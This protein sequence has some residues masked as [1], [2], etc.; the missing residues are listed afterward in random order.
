[1]KI[2]FWGTRGSI[3]VPGDQTLIYGGNTPCVEIR[4]KDEQIIILDAGSGIRKLG[5]D[6]TNR[7]F[8]KPINI[9]FSHY[10]WDH[11]QGLAFFEP[12]Y[13]KNFDINIFGV[14]IN[15]HSVK[16]ML[17]TQMSSNYFPVSLEDLKADISFHNI[18]IGESFIASGVKIETVKTKHTTICLGFKIT[19]DGK[20]VI[21]IPDN[22]LTYDINNVS[23]I[24]NDILAGNKNIVDFCNECD[25]LVHDTMYSVDD[26]KYHLG[27]G[28]SSNFALA[29]LSILSNVKNL[30]IYHHAPERND[31]EVFK[32]FSDTKRILAENNAKLNC[33][34]SREGYEIEI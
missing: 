23:N 8:T 15:G 19:E 33:I 12:I 17:Q 32:L 4:T 14:S 34:L 5:I 2:K 26:Y 16:D 1:M 31:D 20:S 7:K 25:Y 11:I 9:M 22:E 21:Y 30:V 27:W 6:L 10:H 28:H 29:H 24:Q 13:K 18:N 3:P